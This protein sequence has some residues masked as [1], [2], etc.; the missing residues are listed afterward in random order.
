M[1]EFVRE[2]E[3]QAV[4]RVTFWNTGADAYR[5]AELGPQLTAVRRINA[6]GAGGGFELLDHTGRVVSGLGGWVLP[7]GGLG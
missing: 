3:A 7:E 2:K 1:G 6:S 4:L 5:R